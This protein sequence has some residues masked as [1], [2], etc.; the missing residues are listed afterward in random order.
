MCSS[1]LIQI[2]GISGLCVTKLDVLDGVESL[3]LG[4]GYKWNGEQ[5]DLLP[6]GAEALA[7][8]EPVYE[9]IPGWKGSTVGLTRFEQLPQ[10]ARHYLRRIEEICEVPVDMISTGAD[11]AETI[12][13]RHPF[14]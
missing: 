13:R 6:S 12:V 8:C 2:N 3:Q 7:K 10:E 14:E 11:R 5:R 9:E 1:D 4:V